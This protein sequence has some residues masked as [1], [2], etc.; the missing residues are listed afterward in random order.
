MDRWFNLLS[1]KGALGILEADAL[2]LLESSEA[3]ACAAAAAGILARVDVRG[4]GVC[5][6]GRDEAGCQ[7]GKSG[8]GN[9]HCCELGRVL[10][11]LEMLVDRELLLKSEESSFGA[12]RASLK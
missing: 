4:L 2:A 5:A 8:A 10:V 11:M 9:G 6:D 7:N 3:V 1:V 12:D